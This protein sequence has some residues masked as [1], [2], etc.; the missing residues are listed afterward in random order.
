VIG[1]VPVYPG[2]EK[3][4]VAWLTPGVAV[5]IVG[6]PGV[7]PRIWML[8]AWFAVPL[9]FA[10]LTTPVNVP[11]TEGVPVSAPVVPLRAKL[12]GRAP[13]VTLNVGAG[14]P[15]AVYEWL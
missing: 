6:A 1:D 4:I 2:G 5:P 11:A 10:A 9:A 7:A 8:N 14:V 12:V 3:A 15:L 13:D